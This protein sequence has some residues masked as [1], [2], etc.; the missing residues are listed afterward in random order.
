MG[1]RGLL[2]VLRGGELLESGGRL[3]MLLCKG[4][5]TS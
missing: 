1:E 3:E 5:D 2:A 4:A